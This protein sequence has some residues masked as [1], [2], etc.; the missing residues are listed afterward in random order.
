MKNLIIVLTISLVVMSLALSGCIDKNN[1]TSNDVGNDT[2]AGG[3]G[4]S[5]NNT[6][7]STDI[8]NNGQVDTTSDSEYDG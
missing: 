2:V 1:S 7:N 4:I 3:E 6:D 5:G 8:S